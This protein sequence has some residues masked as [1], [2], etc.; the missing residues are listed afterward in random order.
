VSEQER[1]V[2]SLRRGFEQF[3]RAGIEGILSL[4]HPEFE[5]VVSPDLTVEPDTYRGREGVRRYF[6]A[7]EG[8]ME[9]VGFDADQFAAAGDKVFLRMR[10]RAR[11]AGT[12][13]EVTQTAFQVWTMRGGKAVGVV[14]YA[15][16]A[17]ALQAAGIA[18]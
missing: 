13:I 17:E 9:D 18:Q 14:A 11:G 10:L 15:D 3:N 1:N 5:G 2:E 16:R 6:A 12:G 4:I 8:A 7:F